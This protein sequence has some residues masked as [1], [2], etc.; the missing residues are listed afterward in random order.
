LRGKL[1]AGKV[2]GDRAIPWAGAILFLA[3]FTATVLASLPAG[4]IVSALRGPVRAAGGDLSAEDAGI[5]FPAGV[6]L[7]G[8]T[9]SFPGRPPIAVDE[10][11]A[12]WE[13][14]GL[15]RWTPARVR[16]RKGS[17][18]ADLYF[19]PMF[20][21]PGAGRVL[22]SGL[23]SADLPVPIFS[24]GDA[25]FSI[26]RI[27]ARWRLSGGRVSGEGSG[28]LHYLQVPVP[29]PDSP[30]RSARI[31]RVDLS[32]V[33]REGTFQVPRLAGTFEGSA[34]DGTG[35][36]TQVLSPGRSTVTFSLRIRNPFEGRVAAMFDMLSKNAKNAT[37]RITGSLTA[38]AGEFQF[39]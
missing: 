27:E 24:N 22:V 5:V 32:F 21:N 1:S 18:S 36:I 8:V 31:D 30:I 16:L 11:T 29:A 38:P 17:A 13:W 10:V 12:S 37:L 23:S 20:W 14:T 7:S 25:G 35:E 2:P 33:I 6:R 9:L 34:V 4:V 28:T 39:F 15:F 3:V 19:S 26:R